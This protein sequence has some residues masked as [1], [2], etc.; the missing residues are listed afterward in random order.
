MRLRRQCCPVA[1][2][3]A[4]LLLI[5]M[6]WTGARSTTRAAESMRCARDG[7]R[8]V[9][10]AMRRVQDSSARLVPMSGLRKCHLHFD[11]LGRT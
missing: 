7:F 11:P 4:A 10:M 6:R 2:R 9:M 5:R 1:A 8:H 3:D